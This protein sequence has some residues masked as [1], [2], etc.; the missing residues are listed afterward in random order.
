ML[1][2]SV[3]K[4][5]LSLLFITFL[6]WFAPNVVK[7]LNSLQTPSVLIYHAGICGSVRRQLKR[8]GCGVAQEIVQGIS[9]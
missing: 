1:N 2:L 5:I 4:H 3:Y 7:I 8:D 9:A 6:S